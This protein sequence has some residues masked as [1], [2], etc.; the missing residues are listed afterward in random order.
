MN[1]EEGQTPRRI[2][3]LDTTIQLDR[4][5]M[6]RRRERLDALLAEFDWKVT[7]S[8]VLL[9]FK[10]TIVQECITIHNQL[11]RRGARFTYVRDTLLEKQHRQVSLR[12]HIFNNLIS[13]F[14]P[15][16][17]ELTE[18]AD[19]RLAEK[20]RL[21]LENQIPRLY[22]WFR[23]SVDAVLQ[24]ELGCNRAAEPPRKKEVSFDVNLPKCRRGVNKTCCVEEFLRK[25]AGEMLP[26]LHEQASV[27][28]QFE[29]AASVFQAIQNDPA[30]DLSHE[31]CRRVGD[32][33]IMLEARRQA[34]HAL[35]T[36]AKEW[37]PLAKLLG[38]EFVR[39]DYPDEET[40]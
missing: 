3:L 21:T 15:A 7:T 32:C 38:F 12:S 19:I 17:R 18:E 23:A 8:A 37:E 29:R 36:N 33:L 5:K 20:A 16:N 31:A 40:H 10:A 27:S 28:E 22:R 26:W 1:E 35:S 11:R 34:T 30:R 25:N 2:A 39:V 24:D 13:I 14:P 6:P 9:E 4:I